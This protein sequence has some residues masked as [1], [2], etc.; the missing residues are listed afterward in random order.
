MP[1]GM[2]HRISTD[3][4]VPHFPVAYDATLDQASLTG[5][6]SLQRPGVTMKNDNGLD[7]Y[8]IRKIP[9]YTGYVPGVKFGMARTPFPT[10][11][12]TS[13]L[14]LPTLP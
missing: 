5:A 6:M 14:F 4:A 13:V 12:R 11:V 2:D 9:G 3:S 10:Q 7:K 8:A 1:K